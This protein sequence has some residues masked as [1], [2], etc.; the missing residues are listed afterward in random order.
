MTGIPLFQRSLLVLPFLAACGQVA[1]STLPGD[2]RAAIER[3]PRFEIMALDPATLET[4][5]L[6]SGGGPPMGAG[7]VAVDLGD[8][9]WIGAFAGDRILRVARP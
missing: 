6:F 2:M 9:L 7:T 3:A 8:A 1:P 4:E 5:T